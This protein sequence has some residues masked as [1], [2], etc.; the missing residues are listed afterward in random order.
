MQNKG[1]LTHTIFKEKKGI[2]GLGHNTAI[3]PAMA[4]LSLDKRTCNNVVNAITQSS[5]QYTHMFMMQFYVIL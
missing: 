4:W 1:P 5:P 2:R 3:G